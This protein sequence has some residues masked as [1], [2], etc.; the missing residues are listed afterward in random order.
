MFKLILEEPITKFYLKIDEDE[1]DITNDIEPT[2]EI[3]FTQGETSTANIT[4][5][6]GIILSNVPLM[7]RGK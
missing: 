5:K 7:G 3:N 6:N 1:K 4:F 2:L